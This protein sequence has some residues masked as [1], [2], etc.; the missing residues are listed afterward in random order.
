VLMIGDEGEETLTK[1][2]FEAF[3]TSNSN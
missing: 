2:A 1:E 3:L